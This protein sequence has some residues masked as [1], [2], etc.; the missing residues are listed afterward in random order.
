MEFNDNI[1]PDPILHSQQPTG[2]ASFAAPTNCAVPF[3]ADSRAPERELA[4]PSQA[5]WPDAESASRSPSCLHK[6][7]PW[8]KL[9]K[10]NRY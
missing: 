1:P 3:Q 5:A 4:T 2:N 9:H 6:T 7:M 8:H 10:C